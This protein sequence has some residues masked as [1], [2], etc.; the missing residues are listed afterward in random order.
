MAAVWIAAVT[1][2]RVT[3]ERQEQPR[4]HS[5]AIHHVER[6]T[7]VDTRL[8][9]RMPGSFAGVGRLRRAHRE[10]PT[11]G[12]G[13]C[14]RGTDQLPGPRASQRAAARWFA[15]L[16]I[17][18]VVPMTFAVTAC[19]STHHGPGQATSTSASPPVTPPSS[20]SPAEGAACQAP[21]LAAA[22]ARRGGNASAPFVI[23]TLRNTGTAQCTLS[24]YPGISVYAGASASPLP[25]SI[26]HG[27]YEQPDPGPHLVLV[28]SG[29]MAWFALGTSTAYNGG[30]NV[31]V[32]K[33]SISLP[34]GSPAAVA[35]AVPAG[36]GLTS[37]RGSPAPVGITA[38]A[39]GSGT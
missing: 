24:G 39:A 20:S 29:G 33:I 25:I 34:G 4:N 18:L 38:F 27:T 5:D 10:V 28:A 35:L 3:R 13:Q 26:H 17:A 23:V 2:L 15:L 9:R 19:G 14:G 30:M 21:R 37:S 32:T 36:L 8:S 12:P 16:A 7:H 31:L 1:R 11:E 22:I 6:G